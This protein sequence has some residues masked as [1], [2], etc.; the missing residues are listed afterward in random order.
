MNAIRAKVKSRR[1]AS[2]TFALLLFLVCAVASSVI[3]VAASAAGGRISKVRESDRRYYAVTS[4]AEL[5]NAKFTKGTPAVTVVENRTGST[6][7]Y[8]AGASGDPLLA[9]A[10]EWIVEAIEKKTDLEGKALTLTAGGK[11]SLACSIEAAAR[12]NGLLTFT[13]GNG[14]GNNVYK[15]ELTMA[16]VIKKTSVAASA[17]GSVPAHKEYTVTWKLN[18]ISKGQTASSGS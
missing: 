9:K 15:L 10:S 14:R 13:I 12:S 17:D 16:S 3:I 5:L 8:S 18:S 4:A 6:P 1:G 2:I 7:A 11:D